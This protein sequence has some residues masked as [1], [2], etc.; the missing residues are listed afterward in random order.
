MGWFPSVGRLPFA[1]SSQ[2]QFAQFAQPESR[3]VERY[4]CGQE[5]G[6]GSFGKVIA[7]S[8]AHDGDATIAK[9]R[10][11][12]AS[13]LSCAVKVLD[14]EA[15][16][17]YCS[18]KKGDIDARQQAL[19]K[20]REEVQI[21]RM[22]GR[23]RYCVELRDVFVGPKL[24]YVTMERC[25]GT[26][27]QHLQSTQ[28][29]E[30][31]LK[32]HFGE[33]LLATA[34]IH[35]LR[36]VHRDIKPEHFL[37][38]SGVVK[39]CDFGLAAILPRKGLLDGIYGTPPY[40]SPEMVDGQGH[41]QSTDMW[42]L[43][44]T[45]YMILFGE[46]PYVPDGPGAEVMKC[47]IQRGVPEPAFK[48]RDRSD[49]QPTEDAAN[50]TRSLLRRSPRDRFTATQALEQAPRRWSWHRE[51]SWRREATA[52]HTLQ[53]ADLLAAISH[54]KGSKNSSVGSEVSQGR[55][56]VSAKKSVVDGGFVAIDN[57]SDCA[58]KQILTRDRLPGLDWDGAF[59]TKDSFDWDGAS[60]HAPTKESLPVF[61]SEWE[62]DVDD[63][64]QLE[65]D[66]DDEAET[67][68]DCAYRAPASIARLPPTDKRARANVQKSM[69]DIV[70]FV[71]K[72]V[73]TISD[74]SW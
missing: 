5:L 27:M 26:L 39:L 52:L 49:L 42:S 70:A 12:R 44:A 10:S 9:L 21:W 50:F 64:D 54:R 61:D 66:S 30:S 33:M 1:H 14:I 53:E 4:R 73:D 69:A 18:E 58:S 38:E 67:A 51:A 34:H 25:S 24:C 63:Y 6:H 71:D 13:A 7:V 62:C 32:L 17:E 55:E 8:E 19:S 28:M 22:V 35:S 36:I 74:E 31:A 47:A 20:I 23:N 56:D 60:T 68:G 46:F 45:I 37:V 65:D 15:L 41:D 43:G 48:R 57:F 72:T 59:L 3:F 16:S 2:S 40:M 11:D 29:S